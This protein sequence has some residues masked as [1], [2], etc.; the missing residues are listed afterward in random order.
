MVV[1]LRDITWR[2]GKQPI[3]TGV[4]WQIHPGEHW[5]LIGRNGS[6][7]TSLLNILTG[8][9]WPTTGT[10]E[11]LGQ[12]FGSVDLRELRKSIGWVSSSFLQELLSL[13][14][15]ERTLDVVVSG[16]FA[17]MGVYQ[18]PSTKDRADAVTVLD[19]FGCSSLAGRLFASLSQGEKQRVL[20]ARAWM[21]KPQLLILDEPCTGLDVPAREQV[22]GAIDTLAQQKDGP[23]LVYVT[24]HVEEVVP[25]FTHALVLNHGQVLAC[26][27][28]N[29][30]L[31]GN[32]L[33]EA[34]SLPVEVSWQSGRPWL[35]VVSDTP[36]P[37]PLADRFS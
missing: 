13:R 20:L 17:S 30:T 1:S 10:V 9:A 29:E 36:V 8:Y 18:Q 7:K 11:V 4:N 22:L 32:T 24:H 14:P 27:R 15:T 26:G 34:F 6:G 35:Q 25:S 16:K 19:W 37:R 31:T 3:L 23:T 33:T 12:A 28:K 21:G 2:R 5:A